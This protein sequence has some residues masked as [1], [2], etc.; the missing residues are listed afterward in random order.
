MPAPPQFHHVNRLHGT[1]SRS[2]QSRTGAHASRESIHQTIS[3]GDHRAHL[4]PTLV[5]T[6]SIAS[7]ARILVVKL[8]AMKFY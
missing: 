4:Y 5:D 2:H 1:P 6:L 7:L 3:L 8:N